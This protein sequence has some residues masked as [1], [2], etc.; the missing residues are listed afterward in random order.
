MLV[1]WMFRLDRLHY[2][3][4]NVQDYSVLYNNNVLPIICEGL[5]FTYMWKNTFMTVLLHQEGSSWPIKLVYPRHFL[6]RRL[7][8]VRKVSGH[9]F[10]SN[11]YRI[12][13][14]LRF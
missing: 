13:L 1:P 7:H 9:V 8:H 5:H 6:L 10:L 12:C 2:I 3:M 4:Y 11:W 14:F